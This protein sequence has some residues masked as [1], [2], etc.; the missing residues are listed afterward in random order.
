MKKAA[1]ILALAM[2]L[3]VAAGCGE[4]NGEA[5]VQSVSMICGLGSAGL[6]DR[7]AGVVSALGETNIKK[8]DSMTVGEIKVKVGDAVS[9][10]DVLFTYDMT[11]LETNLLAAQLELESLKST[12]ADKEEE[13]KQAEDAL[14]A[15]VDDSE[16]NKTLIQIRQINLEIRNTNASIASKGR[17]IEKLQS[18]MKNSEVKAEVAGEVKSVNPDGGTDSQGNPLPLISIVQT[19]GFRVKGYVNESNASVLSEGVQVIIRSRV[20]DQTWSGTIS[21]IDW[22]NPAKS[23]NNNYYDSGSSDTGNSSKYPFYV[24]LSS[25]DGLLMGQHVYIEPDLG[26]DAQSTVIQLPASFINDADSSPWVWAQGSGG[27]LEKRSLTLGD[28][29]AELDTYAVTDGLTAADYIAFPDDTLKA[30]MT[31]VTYDESTFDPSGD[32]SVTDGGV[33]DGGMADGGMVDGGMIEGGGDFI[34]ADDAANGTVDMPA[35]EP[36]ADEPVEG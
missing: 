24:T 1:F 29:N 30:G 32:D 31:C 22:N 12:L 25:S 36:V 9:V 6:T 19:G 35:D 18:N 5:S 4:S 15:I 21:S 33:T 3:G 23:S 14:D 27:K 34:P 16:R 2:L 20:S 8:D 7:F 26:Q 10:G 13:K 17:D 11:D 28:Y